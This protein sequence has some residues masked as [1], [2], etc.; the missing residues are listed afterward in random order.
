[1]GSEVYEEIANKA[2]NTS[3][4]ARNIAKVLNGILDE[5]L[6]D[7][8]ND[9]TISSIKIVND[10]GVFKPEYK[11]DPSRTDQDLVFIYRSTLWKIWAVTFTVSIDGMVLPYY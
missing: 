10:N 3:I 8:S 4:G 9:I 7:I 5:C 1:M 2:Y 11:H 6:S